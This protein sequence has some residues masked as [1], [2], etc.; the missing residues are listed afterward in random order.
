MTPT[1][2]LGSDT[3]RGA[4]FTQDQPLGAL[5]AIYAQLADPER[6]A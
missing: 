3:S 1:L 5:L 4:R 2:I 6:G